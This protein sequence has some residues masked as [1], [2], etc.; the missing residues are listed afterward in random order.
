MTEPEFPTP[1]RTPTADVPTR[2]DG[3]AT[4]TSGETRRPRRSVVVAVAIVAVALVGGAATYFVLGSSHSASRESATLALAFERGD[5]SIFAMR[6]TVNGTVDLGS[7]G[8][9]PIDMDMSQTIHWDVV[10]VADDGTATVRMS[11]TDVKGTMNGM[12]APTGTGDTTATFTVTPDGRILDANGTALGS[13]GSFGTGG[14]PGMNQLTPILPD[15]PV[16]P[17]DSWEKHFS[18][19]VPYGDGKIEYT[20]RS[21]FDRYE[22]VQGVSAGVVQTHYTVPIDF[23]FDVGEL[24]G[25]FGGSGEADLG[26]KGKNAV[27]TFGGQGTFAQTSWLD[28]DAKKLLRSHSTGE[29]GMTLSMPGLDK[30]LG[31]DRFEIS[32]TFTMDL[33]RR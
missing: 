23:S 19:D 13:T 18:Q 7:L 20:A 8:Q 6:M 9:Q 2:P 28:L 17:G 27:M 26:P 4:G 24:G 29:F 25:M 5:E 3:P 22:D 15:H 16:Q 12:A 14:F 33:A 1:P 30:Q 31:S 11:A 10:R 21:S 32:A